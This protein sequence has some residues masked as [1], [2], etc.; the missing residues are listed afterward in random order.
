M[1]PRFRVS[2]SFG[3]ITGPGGRGLACALTDQSN[4]ESDHVEIDVDD[5]NAELP[6]PPIDSVIHVE[7]GYEE[8]GLYPMGQFN[9]REVTVSGWGRIMRIRA[10][11]TA[12]TTKFKQKRDDSDHNKSLAENIEKRAKRNGWTAKIAPEFQAAMEKYNEQS[13]ESDLHWLTRMALQNGAVWKVQDNVLSFTKRGSGAA[14]SGVGLSGAVAHYPFNVIAYTAV[15]DGRSFSPGGALGRYVQPDFAET[16]TKLAKSVHSGAVAAGQAAA[17]SAHAFGLSPFWSNGEDEA[18]RKAKAVSDRLVQ[19]E[20]ELDIDLIGDPTIFAQGTLE[21]INVRPFVDGAW[22]I[23]VV[24]HVIDTAGYTTSIHA[25]FPHVTS[26]V[27]W[28]VPTL[29]AVTN[30]PQLPAQEVDAGD[31]AQ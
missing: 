14:A 5:R 4:V 11:G 24:K 1:Q 8:T 31:E 22:S 2:G 17:Q 29:T 18:Y 25:E 15:F 19:L 7:M 3:V 9:I 13:K 21:V 12:S 20:G 10:E 26:S 6:I 27:P 16:K 28:T 23:K 30:I